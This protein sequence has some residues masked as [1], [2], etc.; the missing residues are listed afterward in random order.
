MSRVKEYP[1]LH[2]GAL[3][4]PIGE[5]LEAQGF[6]SG[7]VDL[8]EKMHR[9]ANILKVQGVLSSYETGKVYARIVRKLK[10]HRKPEVPNAR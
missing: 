8:C 5:Q 1:E 4:P 6:V 10:A 3:C 2:F 7:E 9:A